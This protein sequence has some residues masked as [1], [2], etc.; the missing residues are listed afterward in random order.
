MLQSKLNTLFTVG[1]LSH[2]ITPQ[3]ECLNVVK[4][5]NKCLIWTVM[6]LFN[7]KIYLKKM[8]PKYFLYIWDINYL[9]DDN[10][11]KFGVNKID[12]HKINSVKKIGFKTVIF[13]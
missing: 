13:H 7:V 12:K 9:N 6:V 4:K 1:I 2:D 10:L 5:F 11:V 8:E 3:S